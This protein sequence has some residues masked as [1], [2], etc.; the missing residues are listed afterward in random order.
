MV[1]VAGPFHRLFLRKEENLGLTQRTILQSSCGRIPSDKGRYHEGRVAEGLAGLE[2]CWKRFQDGFELPGANPIGAALCSACL[3]CPS[4]SQSLWVWV[5][6][7]R[8]PGAE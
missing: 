8:P 7:L 1:N 2:N 5:W 6:C 3:C 4:L